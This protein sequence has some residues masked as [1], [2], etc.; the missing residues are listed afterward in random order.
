MG[1]IGLGSVSDYLVHH[2][3]CPVLVVRKRDIA[4][5]HIESAP[6]IVAGTA[7]LDESTST[8]GVLD[9][10]FD[11][12]AATTAHAASAAAED[13]QTSSEGAD[14]VSA[15]LRDVS[16]RA[17]APDGADSGHDASTSATGKVK[18][19]S[20]STPTHAGHLD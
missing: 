13:E 2:L 9:V 11:V 7:A 15:L 20:P 4:S 10:A 14:I 19:P 12:A 6:I 5:E 17:G 8:A 18:S 16:I 3:H 1:L